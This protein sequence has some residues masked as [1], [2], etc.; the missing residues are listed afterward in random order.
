MKKISTK[1]LSIVLVA[2][3]LCSLTAC[4]G[5][6][7]QSAGAKKDTESEQATISA[8]NLM[9][10]IEKD[11]S[12]N[13]EIN[14]EICGNG[15]PNNPEGAVASFAIKLFQQSI[16]EGENTLISPLSIVTAL[17]MTANGAKNDTL[18]QMENVFDTHISGLNGYLSEYVEGLPQGDKYKLKLANSIWFSK[19]E[20][21][22]VNQEFLQKNANYYGADIY[23]AEFNDETL[24]D[25]NLWVEQKTDGMIKDVLDKIAPDAVMYL[26]NALA[27]EAEWA[28][29]YEESQ[30]RDGIFTT[31]NGTEQSVE[32]MYSEESFYLENEQST[33]F[34]KHYAGRK[35]AFVALLPKEGITV[36]QL[37][38]GLSG[39][40]LQKL[41][42]NPQMVTVKAAIPQ[43]ETEYSVLL[44]DVLREMGMEDA[45]HEVRADFSG[46][47][48]SADGN[49]CIN[50]VIH[51]TYI[52]VGPQGTKAGAATVVEMKAEC[53]PAEPMESKTVYLD[54]PFVYML[55]D[56]ENN[57]P[58]FIG[59]MMSVIK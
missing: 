31:E 33:G 38:D 20:N 57:Q 1:L 7:G 9:K 12:I 13:P 10:D 43:F 39:A 59:T 23:E 36:T 53:A 8:T 45:F 11:V 58:F 17:A 4:N 37:V 40:R 6:G 28:S 47:G 25:I 15:V 14:D 32:M 24:K 5:A 19:A 46:L 42:D 54:R 51:K 3:M 56:C 49:I 29:T 41:L 18:Y 21:F 50:R 48:E 34:I 55:I 52:T 44:N 26:I 35:Y 16:Q 22:T 2:V 30:V 27:F